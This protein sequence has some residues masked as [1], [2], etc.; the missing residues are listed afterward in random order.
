MPMSTIDPPIP[1]AAAPTAPPAAPA[2]RRPH[3]RAE[4]RHEED[5]PEQQ[6]PER[7]VER[8]QTREPVQLAGLRPLLRRRPADGGRVLDLDETLLLQVEDRLLGHV[9]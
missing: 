3:R 7:A 5:E 1:P 8:A 2:G 4:E 6:A 9:G